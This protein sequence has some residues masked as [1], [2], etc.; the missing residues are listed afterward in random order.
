[1]TKQGPRLIFRILA[2]TTAELLAQRL[3]SYRRE[4]GWLVGDVWHE[5][6]PIRESEDTQGHTRLLQTEHTD[7]AGTVYPASIR[8]TL[9]DLQPW[10]AARVSL[11]IYAYL[12]SHAVIAYV[13]QVISNLLAEYPDSGRLEYSVPFVLRELPQDLHGDYSE[14]ISWFERQGGRRINPLRHVWEYAGR[15]PDMSKKD[16]PA[17]TWIL[18]TP[19]GMFSTWLL[20]SWPDSEPIEIELVTLHLGQMR[21]DQ[22]ARA[23][24]SINLVM[25]GSCGYGDFG[26]HWTLEEMPEPVI[27]LVLLPLAADRVEVRLTWRLDCDGLRAHLVSVLDAIAARWPELR[28][29]IQGPIAPSPQPQTYRDLLPDGL[30]ITPAQDPPAGALSGAPT[31]EEFPN[32]EEL[33]RER[34]FW[35]VTQTTPAPIEPARSTPQEGLPAIPKPI[36]L[37]AR[38]LADIERRLLKGRIFKDWHLHTRRGPEDVRVIMRRAADTNTRPNPSVQPAPAEVAPADDDIDRIL[39]QAYKM[40]QEP[41]MNGEDL[42]YARLRFLWPY[43]AIPKSQI[44]RVIGCAS[45]WVDRKRKELGLPQRKPGRKRGQ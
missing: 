26:E 3:R 4:S 27:R 21:Q 15:E 22:P 14:L 37:D 1:M 12:H 31:R 32:W 44:A 23:D 11:I 19:A 18:D 34:A 7:G 35:L 33:Q 20:A 13:Y 2:P 40:R 8:Y 16:Y 41:G 42:A 38:R 10:G 36:E 29:T 6:S 24:G 45:K 43:E 30:R 9:D 25:G 17:V 28:R 5:L 39:A